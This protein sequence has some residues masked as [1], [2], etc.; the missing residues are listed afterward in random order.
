MNVLQYLFT[1][2]TNGDIVNA[3]IHPAILL[4]DW[5]EF[6]RKTS[7]QSDKRVVRWGKGVLNL[8]SPGHPTEIV[9]QLGKACCPCS[10]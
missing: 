3:S 7:K 8:L 9:L 10:K 6:N 1:H 4:K 5:K 2:L